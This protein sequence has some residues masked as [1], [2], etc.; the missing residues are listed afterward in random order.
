MSVSRSLKTTGIIY[1]RIYISIEKKSKS[2]EFFFIACLLI[3][4]FPQDILK[5][6]SNRGDE[7][8]KVP[9]VKCGRQFFSQKFPAPLLWSLH[10]LDLSEK[11][12]QYKY[13]FNWLFYKEKLFLVDVFL[14]K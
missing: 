4:F 3:S 13:N 6:I 7:F 9:L 11:E 1:K 8:K 14:I 12:K 2:K 10:E 5:K